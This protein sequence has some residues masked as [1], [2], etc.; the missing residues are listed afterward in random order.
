M[1]LSCMMLHRGEKRMRNRLLSFAVLG[2]LAA[3]G[4]TAGVVL[5]GES[6]A[7]QAAPAAPA[8]TAALRAQYE[9]WRTQFK[10]WGKWAPVGQESRGTSTLITPEKTAAALRLVRNG[11]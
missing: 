4:L 5:H 2:G 8:D 11:I 1:P 9:Q 3:A 6:K 10:T 7:A